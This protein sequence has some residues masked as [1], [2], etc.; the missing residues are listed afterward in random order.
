MLS[1]NNFNVSKGVDK[2]FFQL[3]GAH[4]IT[5]LQSHGAKESCPLTLSMEIDR[6]RLGSNQRD[7]Y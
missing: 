7:L 5:K 1:K 6:S 2:L 4:T 3:E